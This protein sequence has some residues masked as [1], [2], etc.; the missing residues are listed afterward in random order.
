MFVCEVGGGVQVQVEVK[1]AVGNWP[2][3]FLHAKTRRVPSHFRVFGTA[4][5]TD[6]RSGDDDEVI[7]CLRQKIQPR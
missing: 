6:D 5:Q 1:R 3:R 4:P 7:E 2:Q